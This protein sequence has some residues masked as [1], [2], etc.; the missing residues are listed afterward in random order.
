MQ[1]TQEACERDAFFEDSL[2]LSLS[3]F[4]RVLGLPVESLTL[5]FDSSLQWARALRYMRA[6]LEVR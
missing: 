2:M 5:P 1:K 6:A 3:S 4:S